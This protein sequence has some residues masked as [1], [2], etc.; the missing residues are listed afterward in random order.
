MVEQG[1]TLPRRL[2][3][4]AALVCTAQVAFFSTTLGGRAAHAQDHS[5]HLYDAAEQGTFNVG[6]ARAAASRV[7]DTTAG[8][9]VVKL[10]YTMPPGTA[11]GIW[12]KAFRPAL[13]ADN[14]DIVRTGARTADP[15]Q[16]RHITAALEI[17]GTAGTQ[18]IPLHL[19]PAWTVAEETVNWRAIGTLTEV[20]VLLNHKGDGEPTVG[21]VYFD[22][23]FEQLSVLRKLSML[24][25][26]RM[27]GVL[28][29]SLLG[30]ILTLCLRAL[31][32]R[33]PSR[34]S[35]GETSEV[36][37]PVAR[38]GATRLHAWKRDLVQG[39]GVVF[40]AGLAISIYVLGGS[41]RLEI[42]WTALGLAVAGAGL[43]EWWK[44]G[45]T[46]KHLQ[47]GEVFQDMLVSGLLAAS[48]SSLPV[49][50]APATW[51][52][53]LLLSRTVAAAAALLYHTANAYRLA[54]SGRHLDAISAA[55]I[56][57]TPYLV[58]GLLLLASDGLLRVLVSDLTAGALSAW[59]ALLV[60][61]GRVFVLFCFNEAVAN[62][63]SVATKRTLLKSVPAHLSLFAVAVGAVAAPGIAAYGSSATVAS[64]PA[65]WRL[66]ATV[67][68]TIFSQAGLWA[69]VYL[70]TG[71]V[72][73]AIHGQAPSRTSAYGHPVQG[74]QKAMV[75]SGSFMG[76]VY[77]LGVLGEIPALR[78]FADSSPVT[79]A[80]FYGALAFPLLKTI[81]ESFDGSPPFFQRVVKSYR[82]P[83]LYLRGAVVGVGLGYGITLAL[84][85][86]EMSDRVWFGFGVGVA[87]FAGVNVLRDF[88]AGLRGAGRV[89]SW[90]V[91]MVQALLGGF[92]GA[93]AGFYFDATQVSVVATKF[94]RYFSAGLAPETYGVYPLVSKW[95]YINL[96][97][98]T[99]GVSLLFA[100]SLAGVISWSV[101]AW[102]FALNRAFLAAYFRKEMAPITGLFTTHGLIQ[103]TQNMIE[104][105]RWGLWMSPVINSFLRPIGEPT[106]YNQD[107]LIRTVMAIFHDVTMSPDAFRAW[108]L[109]VFIALL[110][111]DAVR[112]LIWL[113]HMGLRVAT[114]VNLSF[115][116]MDKLEE[117]LARFLAPAA[118]ARCIPEAVK[119]FTTWAP[120]LIPFYIPRG[121]DWDYAWSQAE[122][123]Q[124]SAQGQLGPALSTLALPGKLLLLAGAVI[125]STALF[126]M[127]RWLKNRFAS[128]PLRSSSLSNAVYE[129]VLK[130]NGEL[131]SRARERDYDVSRR[132][133]DFLDPA[134]RALFVVDLAG[135]G[136]PSPRAWPIVGTYPQE[137]ADKPG[138]EVGDHF[139][140]VGNTRD[141]LRA[142]IEISLPNTTDPAELWTITIENLSGRSRPIKVVPYLE[143][144]LNKPDAD[145]GHTQYNRLFAELEYVSPLHAILAWDKHSKAMGLLATDVA[146]E[147]FLSSRIDFIGRA[148]SLWTPR[149]LETLAFAKPQ[150]TDAHPTF[151][152]IGSLLIGT[153]LAPHEAFRM[154]LVMG[155]AGNRQHA[156]DLIARHLG[157]AVQDVAAVA[158]PRTTFHPIRHGE[159]PV[160]T[161]HPY[162]EF[163]PD[164]RRL[165]VHTPF[166]PR[167]YDHTMSNSRGHII[168]VTNRGLHTTANGNSQQNRLTPDW[169]DIVTREVP[170]EAFYLYDPDRREW[171]SPTYHPLNDA[172]PLHQVDFGVDGT[173]T[174]R[175]T[176]DTLETE[177]TVFV[178]PED[179]A[180][181]YVLTVRNHA[182]VARR[183]RLAPYFQMVLA[184]QPE[185]AGPL[186]MRFEKTLNTFFFE[187][188]RNTFR[189]GPAF[190]ASSTPAQRVESKRS[191][192]FGAGRGVAHPYFVEH[193]EPDTTRTPDDRP[194]AAFLATIEIPARSEYTAVV[195]L[196]QADNRKQAEH[197]IHKYRTVDAARSALDRT[198]TWWL[199]LMDTVSV[200]TTNPEF[201]RYLDWLK[202]QV[203]AERIWARR[204]FYQASG[205]YG[206]R[207]QL[208]D[209]V[210]LLWVDPVLARRQILLHASQQFL[211]GDVV[212][213]FH[214]LQDGR[215]GFAGR[216]HAS[217]N[218]LWLAWAA[219]EYVRAT[220][221]DPLL[222][223]RTPYLEAEQPFEPLPAGKHGM[224]FDPLR[225]SR[226]D[227]VYRHCLKAIDLVLEQRMGAHG[228]P[229]MGTGDWNDGLDE[230]GSRGKGESVWLGFFLYYIL[231][232]MAGIVGTK[233]GAARQEY[234]RRRLQELKDALEHT[235]R[236]DRY[237]RAIHDDGTEIGVKDSGVWEIDALTAAWAVMAGINPR[238]GRTVFDTAL[239]ILE[240]EKTIL[241]GWPPLRGDT[242]PYLGRSS[243]Y[244]EGVR[245][246][247][248]YCHGVQWLVGAARILAEHCARAGEADE[249]RRY[250]ETAYRLWLKISPHPH[251]TADEIETYG[252]QPNKQAADLV[253]TFD[254][255]RM[256][257]HGYTG[258][259]GW[260]FRQ[261][262]E[263]VLGVQLVGGEMVPPAELAPAGDVSL[264]RISR[265]VTGSPLQG[266]ARLRP[267]AQ[268]LAAEQLAHL[269]KQQWTSTTRG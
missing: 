269:E 122:A 139:L 34:E 162:S 9:D 194:V 21:T 118:T 55:L 174:Y 249:A 22:I 195:V 169:P 179:P 95:G 147:G 148:R 92:I 217:D 96:G 112:I 30:A 142:T 28:L 18:R 108:S 234:Y 225:S 32:R 251:V 233:E 198:R 101:P 8:G 261:A 193:G 149:V 26:A 172:R 258:A 191:R 229:L 74:M 184:G 183:L 54:S 199:S 16:L 60:F 151:D 180:G 3:Q 88:L 237:L 239:G 82:N 226:E 150:D 42:G 156:I 158:R 209:A 71:M 164:G 25:G 33:W 107:G 263:G 129:V 104:V 2:L 31:F 244:P 87:A 90:R 246:N 223:E 126:S 106:W 125:V 50:Q 51:S 1:Q 24:P 91:Y 89:Q 208:Q 247:G 154:R 155:L 40:I 36:P 211:E 186:R 98:V 76:I 61:V 243:L 105:L 189:T 267:G 69:E 56:V 44:Y 35:S 136:E 113:D 130:E 11:A 53:L 181:V 20:V 124:R 268:H 177:L 252:G 202:Y 190:V 265:D 219:V 241:L 99:G 248:M 230:I 257:W 47:A 205:A 187:N 19:H 15:D 170:A 45:L 97:P 103:L 81:I 85:E 218:L 27:G 114:L 17:K 207:D 185:Y 206:F 39:A 49:L 70:L 140:T 176:R 4:L 159:I 171:F 135:D 100:E 235:W 175:M 134:G 167:P 216:T 131:L 62:G 41:G 43:A 29:A 192:F 73:D 178:P 197:V 259:A 59:P 120:L 137:I 83:I 102:L 224:G 65:A 236:G 168:S 222:D 119:R 72:L 153:T 133:Y 215:T 228:L 57:G 37:E 128:R 254:P 231:D 165:L 23:G 123:L 160:G 266:P 245:E 264:V 13:N 204:G 221:D 152:P 110:A 78:S 262:L 48:A 38:A 111:Y 256:I 200:E 210:N 163:S 68:T 238:R 14:A 7:F 94:Q 188:P 220:G 79:C 121:R 145:R 10:D 116:G 182:D 173:A 214:C 250:R 12:T 64:W 86:K 141:G 77:G 213:W 80:A 52:E 227:S 132:S 157:V 232:R 242:K 146:P 240:K 58:G 166:T 212:H 117:R 144:V 46:G 75:F 93:A 84:A 253:T 255:G 260:L 5:V 138:I 201:D 196:G 6:P 67:L 127:V 115:L 143:W 63:L 203:L 161:P 66:I 109:Q